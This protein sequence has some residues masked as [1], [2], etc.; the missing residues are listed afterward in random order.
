[1]VV[2]AAD[3]AIAAVAVDSAALAVEVVAVVALADLGKIILQF[4]ITWQGI[5]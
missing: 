2:A 3:G 1:V 5:L 4:N